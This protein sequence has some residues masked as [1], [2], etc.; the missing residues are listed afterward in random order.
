M[1][2]RVTIRPGVISRSPKAKQVRFATALALTRTAQDIQTNSRKMLQ[3]KLDNPSRWTLNSIAIVPARK[4]RL[5]ASVFFKEFS[6]KGVA[7]GK[8]LVHMETG[9]QRAQKRFEAALAARGVIYPWQ[10]T[11]PA[12]GGSIDLAGLSGRKVG[13]IYTRILSGLQA[14]RDA[15]QDQTPRSILRRTARGRQ[16]LRYFVVRDQETRLATAIWE[17]VGR[18]VARPVL[19]VVGRARYGATLDFQGAAA[20]TFAARMPEQFRRALARAWATAR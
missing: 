3:R 11:I 5:N 20:K 18:N 1:P 13:G 19:I 17:R 14:S 12:D 4:D 2:S 7:A 9:G 8:Y 16:A 15:A 10:Y 6:G